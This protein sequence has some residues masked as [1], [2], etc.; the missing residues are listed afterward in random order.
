MCSKEEQKYQQEI[1][2]PEIAMKVLNK[3]SKN[4]KPIIIKDGKAEIDPTHPD[5]KYWTHD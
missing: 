4:K 2:N 5:Y 1:E 3:L